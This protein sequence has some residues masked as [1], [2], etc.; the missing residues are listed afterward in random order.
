MEIHEEIE[1]IGSS[2]YIKNHKTLVISDLHI[3]FE[4]SLNK[5]GVFL[6]RFQ[7]GD[8][9]KQL[10]A[11]R[12]KA[13]EFG[14]IKTVVLNG[15]LKHEFGRITAQERRE[16]RNLFDNFKKNNEEALIVKGNHDVI[17]AAVAGLEN[18]SIVDKIELGDILI[19]HGD[20]VP[21]ELPIKA[22]VIIIGHEHPSVS[23]REG[24]RVERFKCF[25]KGKWKG[26]TLLVM[27]SFN[28]LVEGT[29]ILQ[30]NTL[31]PFLKQNLSGFEIWV[32]GEKPLYF[33]KVKNLITLSER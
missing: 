29:D 23:L 9:I 24:E 20:D 31:S 4:E 1:M 30:E 17:L 22:K 25:L 12:M 7:F 15:D 13:K 10:G 21:A 16:L 14:G 2:I 33:G 19:I 3:G 32:A 18:Y 11:I 5:Q 6:P 28:P 26:R 8:I 27:P